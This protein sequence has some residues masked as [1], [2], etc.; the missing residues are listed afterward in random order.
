MT[1]FEIAVLLWCFAL[2]ASVGSF[3]NVVAWRLPL[4]MS[5]SYPASHCPRC[6]SPIRY[7][8]NIPVLG[9]LALRGRCRACS[10][11][12]SPRYPVVEFLTGAAFASIAV[13]ELLPAW[14][15]PLDENTLSGSVADLHFLVFVWLYHAALASFLIV[16]ALFEIDD[17]RVPRKFVLVILAFGLLLPVA[18]E[19]LPTIPWDLATDPS[20]YAWTANVLDHAEGAIGGALLAGCF[21]CCFREPRGLTGLAAQPGAVAWLAT[22]AFLGWRAGLVIASGTTLLLCLLLL[23]ELAL[24]QNRRPRMA[25]CTAVLAIGYIVV[26]QW[27]P[28]VARLTPADYRNVLPV[29]IPLLL[30]SL[31]LGGML[32][33]QRTGTGSTSR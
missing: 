27:L 30:A 25:L 33:W 14:I 23:S 13:G 24:R 20:S 7:R 26:W 12:I 5:L 4:G 22:G 32:R 18:L 11:R 21:A 6:K 9:W 29:A 2:G 8:D 1:G 19:N 15:L 17:A 16:L 3:L 28:P 31:A 10:T